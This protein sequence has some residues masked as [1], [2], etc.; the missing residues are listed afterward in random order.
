MVKSS[1]LVTGPFNI[2]ISLS[3]KKQAISLRLFYHLPDLIFMTLKIYRPSYIL[4]L[5][6]YDAAWILEYKIDKHSLYKGYG[7]SA[8]YGE[9]S[10]GILIVK[11]KRRVTVRP[12]GE[13]Q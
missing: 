5:Q 12:S 6:K 8:S 4:L 11:T 13:L 9:A 3:E 1:K 2:L 7:K 10:Y